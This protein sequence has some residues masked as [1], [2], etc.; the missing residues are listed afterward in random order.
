M[1]VRLTSATRPGSAIRRA[2]APGAV[3]L[4]LTVLL[5]ACASS[6]PKVA[7]PA[8]SP[9]AATPAGPPREY[10]PT[11]PNATCAACHASQARLLAT[12]WAWHR[13]I[14][15][16]VCHRAPHASVAS[17]SFCHR[18]PHRGED[19]GTACSGCHGSAHDLY[20]L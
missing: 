17:C 16:A 1:P 20:P 3:L 9:V 15:C 8:A 18:A 12:T 10:G 19:R 4:G 2:I 7:T 6:S 5:A 11:T 13:A 14:N